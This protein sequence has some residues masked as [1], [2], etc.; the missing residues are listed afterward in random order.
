MRQARRQAAQHDDGLGRGRARDCLARLAT[1]TPAPPRARAPS[2]E[3]TPCRSPGASF[4]H[5]NS[6]DKCSMQSSELF[7]IR[8]PCDGTGILGSWHPNRAIWFRGI[9]FN[10]WGCV[11]QFSLRTNIWVS[12]GVAPKRNNMFCTYTTEVPTS[13]CIHIYLCSVSSF[14]GKSK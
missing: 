11:T 12:L 5:I 4:T 10:G 2:S 3:R 14:N 1:A 9:T 13:T 6:Y 7:K 8:N